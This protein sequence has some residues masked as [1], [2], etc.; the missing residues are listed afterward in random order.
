MSK[1][2]DNKIFAKVFDLI[3]DILNTLSDKS[4]NEINMEI[5]TV[6]GVR[7][8]IKITNNN[9]DLIRMNRNIIIIDKEALRL[10]DIGLKIYL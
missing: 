4:N 3:Y 1:R 8:E 6:D 2:N 7:K 5:I 10:E 9:V